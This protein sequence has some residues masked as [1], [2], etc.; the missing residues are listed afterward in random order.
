MSYG[1]I[2]QTEI[3]E[4][5]SFLLG[6]LTVP[7]SGIDDRKRFVQRTLEEAWTFRD[8]DFAKSIATITVTSGIATLPSGA[9]LNGVKDV[10]NVV[11]GSG[12]DRVY[13]EV[14]FEEK[15]NYTTGDKRYWLTGN[16]PN[17]VI[18]TKETYTPLGVQYIALP[19]Q[20]NASVTAAF[21]DSMTIAQ[22]AL[23]FV[24]LGENPSADIALEESIFRRSLER[25][26]AWYNT[27]Q[28]RRKRRTLSSD[29][30]HGIGQVGG[31]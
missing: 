8:W 31:D 5:L 24:R 6:E 16:T 9:M 26:W 10:R 14:S 17:P 2:N 30:G 19:P 11:S 25:L 3:L 21:P 12:D 29:A 1:N 4:D 7:T 13:Q 20:V 22:G 23:R 28:P 27:Q 18:N 15:D